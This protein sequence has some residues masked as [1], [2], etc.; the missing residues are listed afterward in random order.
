[1]APQARRIDVLPHFSRGRR[2]RVHNTDLIT[3]RLAN[4]A[5]KHREMPAAEH[6]GIGR[7]GTGRAQRGE[8]ISCDGERNRPESNTPIGASLKPSPD[9]YGERESRR[10]WKPSS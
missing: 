4:S 2:R 7:I 5:R 8:I 10:V 1:M 6:E 3:N 9:A